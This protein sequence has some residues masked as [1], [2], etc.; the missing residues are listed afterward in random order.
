M[1]PR[2]RRIN[3]AVTAVLMTAFLVTFLTGDTRDPVRPADLGGLANWMAEH[4]A[5]YLAA[6][7]IADQ[8]LD[9]EVPKRFE[10]WR[11]AYAHATRLAPMRPNPA[12]AFTRGGLFH[13]YEL[14]PSD[15]AAVLK[16]AAPLLRDESTFGRMHRPLWELTGDFAYLRRN[17]PDSERALVALRDIAVTNGRFDD[18][19]EV[20]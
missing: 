1:T 10:L 13:W 18:Y 12:A 11:A 19:R 7:M 17:A 8:A 15:R 14:G 16:A 6:S 3:L 4:P 9:S 5:D 2:A 20:R